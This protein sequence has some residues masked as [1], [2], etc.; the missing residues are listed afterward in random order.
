[1]NIEQNESYRPQLDLINEKIIK[2]KPRKL[3]TAMGNTIEDLRE[4]YQGDH[5]TKKM[6]RK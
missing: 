3:Q 4:Q 6:E 5:Y 2:K 1:M